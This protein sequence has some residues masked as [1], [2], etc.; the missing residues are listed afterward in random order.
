MNQIVQIAEGEFFILH[1]SSFILEVEARGGV[2]PRAFPPSSCRFG[3]EDRR[4]ERGPEFGGD[5]EIRTHTLLFTGQQLCQLELHRLLVCGRG[6]RPTRLCKLHA[7]RQSPF[8]WDESRPEKSG[9]RS[10]KQ[11]AGKTRTPASRTC[12][13]PTIFWC[14]RKDLNLQP[15]V[16]RTQSS[17]S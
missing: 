16:C 11:A 13:L 1:P 14:P 10:S 5:G 3:L 9:D 17:A 8:C 12:R 4:R 7:P 6:V 2:E 15:L